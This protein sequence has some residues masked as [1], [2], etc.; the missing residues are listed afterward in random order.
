MGNGKTITG[1]TT[2]PGRAIARNLPLVYNETLSG[3][4]STELLAEAPDNSIIICD[5]IVGSR[6]FLFTMLYLTQSSNVRAAVLIPEDLEIF[7]SNSFP[8]PGTII[9]SIQAR[10]VI[11]YASNNVTPTAS[12]D[13]QLANPNW[14]QA[15]SCSSPVR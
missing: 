5:L 2:F 3:C 4:D 15:S 7:R 1:W 12:I 14:D 13:F 10:D 9:S 6:S 11:S 8:F